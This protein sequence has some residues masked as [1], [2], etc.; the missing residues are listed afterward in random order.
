MKTS[1]FLDALIN[2]ELL[3][4]FSLR[5]SCK[6]KKTNKQTTTIKKKKKKKTKKKKKKKNSRA[7]N[8]ELILDPKELRISPLGLMY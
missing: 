7:V 2:I 8:E 4:K 1:G 5:S 3:A 6:K